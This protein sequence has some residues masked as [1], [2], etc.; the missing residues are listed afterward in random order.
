M[1]PN[2]HGPA[3]EPESGFTVAVI[4]DAQNYVS[5]DHQVA[6]G[7]PFDAREQLFAQ[8]RYVAENLRSAG[9][10]I[11]FVTALGDQWNHP[12]VPIDA[13]HAARGYRYVANPAVDAFFAPTEKT[14]SVEM[15]TV[16]TAFET[17]AGK[18]PLCV[19]PGNHDFDALWTDSRFPPAGSA[20]SLRAEDA[21]MV[22]AGG[23]DNFRAV[24]GAGTPFFENQPWYVAAH[25]GGA[26]SAQLFEAGGYRFLSIGLQFNAPNAALDWA[27][28][29]LADHPGLPTILMTHDFLNARGEHVPYPASDNSVIDPE[30]NNSAMMWEK[31]VSRHDQIFLV[32]CGHQ[33]GQ[34]HRTDLNVAGNEVHQVLADYQARW[35]TAK[36]AGFTLAWPHGVGDGW[37]RLMRF[38]LGGDVPAI[39]V[40]T[41]STHLGRYSSEVPEYA[42]WYRPFEQP[43][44]TDA[45]FRAAE[46]FVIPLPDF[47]RRFGAAG[48]R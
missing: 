11:A 29:V 7:F 27:A 34:A 3:R 46:E 19:V 30:S 8:L 48:V 24:F 14:R 43:A 28:S 47:R 44:M 39:E 36:D 25:D 5:Y 17:I 22:F 42:E 18:V 12:S 21:G 1:T 40:R 33:P 6:E 26:D 41:Y 23:L 31:F 2:D 13:A 9:G 15:P 10:D 32:L 38:E 4:P 20:A 37:M 45:E 35:Q 16:R